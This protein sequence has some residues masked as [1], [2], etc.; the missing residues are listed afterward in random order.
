MVGS[1]ITRTFISEKSPGVPISSRI[2]VYLL[3]RC[4]FVESTAEVPRRLRRLEGFLVET[5]S[6][7]VG[8]VEGFRLGS[9]D[10]MP[11]FLVV[12][13]GRFARR[14]MM[15]S[16]DDIARVVPHQGLVRLR[17]RWMA[18]QA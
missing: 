6:E 18:M 15:I 5:G 7:R 12:R 8:T 13:T 2:G 14:R 10:G 4:A 11:D 9:G 16:V 3:G 1:E 17:S